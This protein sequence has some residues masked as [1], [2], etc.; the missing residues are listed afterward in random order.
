MSQPKEK[1]PFKVGISGTFWAKVPQFSIGINGV[2]LI[3]NEAANETK[4]YEF[5]A[6]LDEDKEH[7]LEIRLENKDNLDTVQSP[8]TEEI[9]RDLILNID[10]IEIDG[11]DIGILKWTK[12]VF[13][14][15]DPSKPTIPECVNLGWNGTYKMKFCCPFYLWLLE[16]V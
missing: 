14:A 5:D 7:T 12:S 8:G 16:N 4:I 13:I 11:I 3:S 10:S 9:I 6:E 15:D 2:T 1:L